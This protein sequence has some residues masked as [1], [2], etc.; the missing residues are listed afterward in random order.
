[1]TFEEKILLFSLQ[2]ILL[3]ENELNATSQAL[4]EKAEFA[5]GLEADLEHAL[6]MLTKN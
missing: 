6:C 5:S 4:Q 2:Q 3:L 1:M